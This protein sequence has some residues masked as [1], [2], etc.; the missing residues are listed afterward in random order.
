MKELDTATLISFERLQN[1]DT[2]YYDSLVLVKE[3]SYNVKYFHTETGLLRNKRN[4][5]LT[6]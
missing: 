1:N 2:P 3:D 4:I 6:P 5:C